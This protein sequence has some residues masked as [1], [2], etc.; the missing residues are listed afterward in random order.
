MRRLFVLFLIGWF[1]VQAPPAGWLG[2]TI[3]ELT[4]QIA[5]RLGIRVREGVFVAA[6]QSGSPADQ[7]GIRAGDVILSL[8]GKKIANPEELRQKIAK[9]SPGTTVVVTLYRDQ[10]E[11]KVEIR[12]GAPPR[13]AA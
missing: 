13:E 4:P 11:R 9:I 8:D 12:V 6:V 2:L 10:Q 1:A 5:M 7:G 3:Q